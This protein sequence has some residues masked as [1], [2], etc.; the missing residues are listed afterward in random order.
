MLLRRALAINENS[1]GPRHLTVAHSLNNLAVLLAQRGDW[2]GAAVIGRRAKPILTTRKLEQGSDRT[3]VLK[4]ELASNTWALRFH[5]RSELR[6]SGDDVRAREEG[7]ELAQWA[8]Q[9]GAADALAQMSM[10][11]AKGAGPHATLIRERQDIIVRRQGELRRLD[12][13]TGRADANAAEAARTTVAGLEQQ[14]DAVDGR[15]ATE[16]KEYTELANPKPLTIAATQA[17]LNPD[18]ALILFLD[19]PQFG[20]LPEETLAWVV[21][22]QDAH[23]RSIALGTKALSERVAALRCGLDASSWLDGSGWS[24]ETA[25][26]RER[27]REQQARRAQCKQ[28]LGLE[29][30]AQEWPPFD[31]A[32]AHALHEALFAPI[33]HLTKGKNLIVVPSGPLTSLPFQVLITE[34]P[35]HAL[36]GMARYQKAAWLAL[37]QPV[38]VLPSVGSLQALRHLGRSQAAEFY[39]AF[40]N[41]LLAGADGTDKRAWDKQTCTPGAKRMVAAKVIARSGVTLRAIDLAKLRAQVPLPETADELCAV[42]EALGSLRRESDSVWLG[43][44]ATERNL[45]A[46]SRQGK[47]AR[48]KVVHFATHGLVSGEREEHNARNPLWCSPHQRQKTTARPQATMMAC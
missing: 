32:R 27:T 17:L 4:A 48:Y 47:L 39:I 3:G 36:T 25:L 5:A 16:F 20:R 29:V 6:A 18:E 40:G 2:H 41:P 33:A 15:L 46:L 14:L 35:D 43:E 13:A 31:V 37:Q 30:S 44:R 12:A 7:F 1:L 28:L 10:R 19:V 34:R 22:K 23:W 24:Q 11:F 45:K 38:T 9:T 21:T 8:L 26:Q 42:A